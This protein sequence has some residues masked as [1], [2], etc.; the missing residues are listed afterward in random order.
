MKRR[1]V[2]VCPGRGTYNKAELGY[3]GRHH[4]AKPDFLSAIDSYRR[5]Q[6]QPTVSELDGAERFSPSTHV[7]GD[8]AAALIFA[9]A[10]GDFLDIDREAFEVV[11]VTGNSMGWYIALACA[12][13]T[14]MLGGIQVVNTMGTLMHQHLI[15]GQLLYP[16]SDEEWRPDPALRAQVLTE[17][18]RIDALP[19]CEAALSIDLGGLLALAG[20][21]AGLAA[22]E[23]ALPPRD[24]RYPMRLPLH[25]AFH[26]A[27]QEPVSVAGKA[28]LPR[29]LFTAPT[30]PLIDGRSHIWRPLESNPEA[31]RDYTLGAQVTQPYH[32]AR[33]IQ[34]A[35]REFAPQVL[36]VPGP[37]TT[38]GGSI[39][40]SL[41][42]IGWHGLESRDDFVELQRTEP[43]VL[44]MAM[45]EQRAGAAKGYKR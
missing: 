31:L 33:A 42:A 43:L 35:V 26:T 2:V 6:G 34:T 25:A 10:C 19:G 45:E 38:L 22:L 29:E 21:E 3:V 27:L 13:A 40:Q 16:V 14:S 9:S 15:G 4:A 17:L 36:I 30:I 24:G 44:A 23:A 28:A 8:N 5:D 39:A 1:A 7:R 32:F 37:G 20:N 12:G 18:A 41:I 11:A